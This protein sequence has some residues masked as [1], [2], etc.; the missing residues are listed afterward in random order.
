MY[1]VTTL[2]TV[3]RGVGSTDEE[4]VGPD[5]GADAEPTGNGEDEVSTWV[6]TAIAA[7]P[8]ATTLTADSAAASLRSIRE[9]LS[10]LRHLE[11]GRD[12]VGIDLM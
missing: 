11:G 2:V 1:V 3:G 10:S 6:L 8:A 4:L 5:G 9:F 7:V 12:V